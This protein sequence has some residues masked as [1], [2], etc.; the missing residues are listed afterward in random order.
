MQVTSQRGCGDE[1]RRY[2]ADGH[3]ER[4]TDRERDDVVS[5]RRHP[6]LRQRLIECRERL[7]P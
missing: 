7:C 2:A 4:V 3:D 6:E 5:L 1:T